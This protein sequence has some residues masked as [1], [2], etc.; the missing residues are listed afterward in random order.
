[1]K[2]NRIV[3][4]RFGF[5]YHSILLWLITWLKKCGFLPD[6]LLRKILNSQK[7]NDRRSHNRKN[8]GRGGKM[9]RKFQH[10]KGVEV[11]VETVDD[12]MYAGQFAI[13]PDDNNDT[14][15]ITTSQ[16]YINDSDE[17][18]VAD[19]DFDNGSSDDSMDANDSNDNG[20][21]DDADDDDE[22]DADIAEAV[23][24]MEHAT[25]KEEE[26]AI[27]SSNPPKTENEVDGY[28]V[29]I[30]DLESQLQIKLTVQAETLTSSCSS[31]SSLTVIKNRNS[32]KT[33]VA[34]KIKHFMITD[35]T[36]VVESVSS[37]LQRGMGGCDTDGPLDEGSLLVIEIQKSS[38][39]DQGSLNS[40]NDNDDNSVVDDTSLIPLGR[41]FEVFGPVSRPLYTIRLPSPLTSTE[42][43]I[44]TKKLSKRNSGKRR[45]KNGRQQ[46]K[47]HH[48][49]DDK[50]LLYVDDDNE[51]ENKDS[52]KSKEMSINVPVDDSKRLKVDDGNKEENKV[53]EANIG[54]IQLKDTTMHHS[55]DNNKLL[56]VDND[57]KEENE[58]NEAN[59]NSIQPKDT[60]MPH[61]IDDNKLLEVDN[62]KKEEIKVN[63]ANCGGIE[64]KNTTMYHSIVDN[65]LWEV[66]D[67]K[68][69]ENE[70]NE[71]NCGSNQANEDTAATWNNECKDESKK[72]GTTNVV[73]IVYQ[74]EETN[75]AVVDKSIIAK[76]SSEKMSPLSLKIGTAIGKEKKNISEEEEM[77]S[78]LPTE[79][80]DSITLLPLVNN[81][82]V[83]EM[84]DAC[85]DNLPT[86]KTSD[87]VTKDDPWSMNGKYSLF[88]LQNPNIQVYYVQDEATIIDTGFVMR[89]SGKGCDASNIYDEEV[90][91]ANDMY[92]SDDEKEREAKNKKKR[93]GKREKQQ[94]QQQQQQNYQ[95]QQQQQ[96]GSMQSNNSRPYQRH[97]NIT[98]SS[99]SQ[100]GNNFQQLNYYQP[101]HTT[102]HSST[103]QGFHGI[104]YAPPGVQPYVAHHY[105]GEL[106]RQISCLPPPPP[107]PPLP[108][109]FHHQNSSQIMNAHSQGRSNTPPPPPPQYQ[110]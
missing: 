45:D 58:V 29:P 102:Q 60:T 67:D 17:I 21:D 27:K 10:N 85:S 5:I 1:M 101:P 8:N 90:L 83:S 66:D 19:D 95:Q 61:S 30:Q 6:K 41:I 106:H 4:Y 89:S 77:I 46:N 44:S 13:I 3:K 49:V 42:K 103:P 96:R 70:V 110:Y 63:E 59:I 50:K 109:G 34:G 38:L 24:R 53:N 54:N 43:K 18:D 69:E 40:C 87:S 74:Q 93:G 28:K 35:R 98:T 9:K 99:R 94:Q 105:Q 37:S 33:S 51:E 100:N 78:T 32:I 97:N 92:Y 57:K 11:E 55:V 15:N 108:K 7:M 104:Q 2:T 107:P 91:N 23:K 22:S 72:N 56:K 14:N 82:K 79:S 75:L 12:L 47:T 73:K 71:E 86:C 48:S 88:L 25:E 31:S 52:D 64:S 80:S 36:V 65:K 26:S 20:K 16:S 68:K 84:K 39:E 76:Q 81:E 62:D